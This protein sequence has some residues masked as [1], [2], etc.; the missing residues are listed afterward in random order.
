MNVRVQDP[1]GNEFAQFL[2]PDLAVTVS[3]VEGRVILHLLLL[4]SAEAGME[5]KLRNDSSL[6]TTY[7]TLVR[8]TNPPGFGIPR[9][10]LWG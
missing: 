1:V 7:V 3:V 8:D 6:A 10:L 4:S 9:G 5:E 2:F